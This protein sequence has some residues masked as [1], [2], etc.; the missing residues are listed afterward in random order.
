M[1]RWFLLAS[2]RRLRLSPTF[3]FQAGK[4]E[5]SGLFDGI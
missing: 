2:G 1:L 3:V 5:R 4:V